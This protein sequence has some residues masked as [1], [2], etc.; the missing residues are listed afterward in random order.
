MCSD[1]CKASKLF[2]SCPGNLVSKIET[3]MELDTI[4]FSAL[5]CGLNTRENS[6]S[7]LTS[8]AFALATDHVGESIKVSPITTNSSAGPYACYGFRNRV[9]VA[10]VRF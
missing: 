7:C 9:V 2:Q 8:Q 3:D 6:D 10:L 4:T 1:H 5:E